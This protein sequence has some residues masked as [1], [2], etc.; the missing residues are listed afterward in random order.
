MRVPA[1]ACAVGLIAET[2]GTLPVKLFRHGTKEALPDHPAYRLMHGEANDWTSAE[3]LRI[4]L[5]ADALLH[6]KGG[7]AV[8]LRNSEGKPIE[9]H[10]L[11]PAQVV[12]QRQD[13]E[14]RMQRRMGGAIPDGVKQPAAPDLARIAQL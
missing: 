6:D 9:L 5:T 12:P 3:A 1:V 11:A 10:R 13:A 4:A 14:Q 8:V 2:V 7:F